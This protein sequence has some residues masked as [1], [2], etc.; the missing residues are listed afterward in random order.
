MAI[1]GLYVSGYFLN[2]DASMLTSYEDELKEKGVCL[3]VRNLSNSLM[4]ASFDFVDFEIIAITYEVLQQFFVSGGYDLTKYFF[5]KLWC[6]ITKRSKFNIPF[7]ISIEGIPTKNGTETI[8]CKTLGY[9]SD[10]EKQKVID[11]TFSLAYQI[12]NHQYH[13]MEKDQYYD[14]LNGHLFKY[15]STDEELHEMDIEAELKK[16]SE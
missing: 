7:T 11:K 9:L 13:L 6:D 12:E 4:Q 5:K 2:S 8:K 15:D 3:K 1:D 16:K 14:A 10:E